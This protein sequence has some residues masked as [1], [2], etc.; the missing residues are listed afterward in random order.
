MRK[1]GFKNLLYSLTAFFI[2]IN[3]LI[4]S[5]FTYAREVSKEGVLAIVIDDFG[6][7]SEGTDAM[8]ALGIPITA[9]IMPFMSTS[10]EDMEKVIQNKKEAI[11]HLP[12][13]PEVGKASW[14][15]PRG[16]VTTLS[17]EEIKNRVKD[18]VK[19]LDK[20]KGINNHMGS[21]AVQDRRVMDNI[22]EIAASNNLF[23]LDS[24]TTA[25]T[26]AGESC[27]SKGVKYY[28]RDIFLDN[29]KD[30]KSIEKQLDKAGKVA[31]EKGYAIAIGHVGVEG[32]SI[33]VQAI[34]NKYK[35]LENKGI[36]FVFLSDIEKYR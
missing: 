15:G 19:E 21:K 20:A 29:V 30:V 3:L 5:D 7:H 4:S 10:K 26:I 35:E 14:L 11:I 1:L 24:K 28:S 6:N 25:K 22:I 18:A 12:M 27:K 17:D 34:K 32:G 2:S 23:F 33:T 16:I 8:L 9:A 31:L 36:K 13:E